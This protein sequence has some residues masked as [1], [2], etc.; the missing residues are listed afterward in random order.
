MIHSFLHFTYDLRVQFHH[1]VSYS[2]IFF[3]PIDR[4][5]HSSADIETCVKCE[6]FRKTAPATAST[7]AQQNRAGPVERVN[8]NL[9]MGERKERQKW[10]IYCYIF[11]Q[12]MVYECDL[13]GCNAAIYLLFMS[14]F[15]AGYGQGDYDR[16]TSCLYHSE[17]LLYSVSR[18]SEPMH[19]L[20]TVRM[21][22]TNVFWHHG[23]AYEVK[24]KMKNARVPVGI[25]RIFLCVV[26]ISHQILR[27][28]K[29]CACF[30]AP[31]RGSET[32]E[33]SHKIDS[34]TSA[35]VCEK[36]NGTPT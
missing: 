12:H 13:D 25:N 9:D 20:R 11:G 23:I 8:K 5:S 29:M 3:P 16:L 4:K 34:Y 33:F 18:N 35:M 6:P 2:I 17:N 15:R 32:S 30:F 21:S 19:I 22:K 36:E 24:K 14:I 1:S 7:G 28:E 31:S 27:S 10:K 26:L